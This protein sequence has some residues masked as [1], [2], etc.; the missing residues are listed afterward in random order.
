MAVVWRDIRKNKPKNLQWYFVLPQTLGEDYDQLRYDHEIRT[1]WWSESN[2][3]FRD[4]QDQFLKAR[5]YFPI[6]ER[7][8]K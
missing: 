3:D 7:Q 8:E 6:V 5:Y 1:G 4:E 2:R